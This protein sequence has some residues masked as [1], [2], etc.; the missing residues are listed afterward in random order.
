VTPADPP[1]KGSEPP[2]TPPPHPK[3]GPASAVYWYELEDGT[4]AF[5]VC[6]YDLNGG[7]KTFLQGRQNGRGWAWNLRGVEPVLYRLGELAEHLSNGSS[8]PIYILEGEKACD[9][10]REHLRAN[11]LS[12]VATC[13]PMGAG[14]W[15]DSYT[16]ALT[17]AR[18]VI[19]VAD[20]DE[21]GRKHA[22][23]I[24]EALHPVVDRL[25]VK[26]AAL[27]QEHAG[28]DD[29]LDAGFGLEQLVE[30]EEEQGADEE[31]PRRTFPGLRHADALKREVP[32]TTQIV[33]NLLE[34]A[35]LGTIAGLPETYKSFLAVAAAC[36]VAAGLDG[37]VLLG[38]LPVLMHGPVGYW[39]QD[40][41][42]A[43]ELR[44]L[45]D[46]AKRHEH[47]GELP[48]IWHLNEGLRLPEDIPVLVE[49]I[50]REG[51]VLTMLDSL[52]NFLPGLALKDEDVAQ[53]LAAVKAEVC[54]KTGC[55]V[56]FIDH[57]PW[58][59]EGNR[60][61]RRGYGSVFKAAVQRW[62][63]YL[64][65]DGSKLWVE[66][67]GNNVRGL[68]RSLAVW[69]EDKLE[70]QL[71]DTTRQEE[72][73]AAV[74]EAVLQ[75]LRG[76]PGLSSTKVREGVEGRN[77][78]IDSALERL[79]ERGEVVDLARDGGAWSGRAGAPRYWHPADDAGLT[80]PALFG[81]RSGEVGDPGRLEGT[82]PASPRTRRVGRGWGEVDLADAEQGGEPDHDIPW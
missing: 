45:Q 81:A 19:V 67:R 60:G 80:S 22:R 77:E 18:H 72:D 48:L 64:E 5:A 11:G 39:W 44:R 36:K 16:E 30:L 50:E 13:N 29:H 51:Q 78:S 27:D 73:A 23:A 41:S 8:A 59:N 53:V 79:K 63:I 26:R 69:D 82:S 35:T 58:P 68:K 9:R 74:E 55:A 14:K 47:T 54:D 3:H 61:Q 10:E 46:Y 52:Y 49:E 21:P 56:G 1:F 70:L 38:E 65:R 6:R 2:P 43:N 75:L 15:R 62:G 33:K 42:E 37:A 24:A 4:P 32:E 71:V 17:G 34:A 25:E 66:A 28:V 76:S 40:D 31:K 12:G 7:G 20:N 57:A